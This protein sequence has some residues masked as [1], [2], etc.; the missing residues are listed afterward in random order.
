MLFTQCFVI[1]VGLLLVR[2]ANLSKDFFFL[3][4]REKTASSRTVYLSSNRT[5]SM[6]SANILIKETLSIEENCLEKCFET[7]G[8][9]AFSFINMLDNSSQ[10]FLFHSC[11]TIEP[12]CVSP[13]CQSC[14]TGLLPGLGPTTHLEED[15][16]IP[17]L[18][19]QLTKEKAPRALRLEGGDPYHRRHQSEEIV[20]VTRST[21]CQKIVRRSCQFS[22][23]SVITLT[24]AISFSSCLD[25]CKETPNCSHFTY[26]WQGGGGF[27]TSSPCVLYRMCPSTVWCEGC[28]TA[29]PT[30]CHQREQ[31]PTKA[32]KRNDA[33]FVA[34]GYALDFVG[35]VEMLS[36]TGTCGLHLQ[37]MPVPKSRGVAQYVGGQV[38]VC[39]GRSREESYTRTCVGLDISTG[40][41]FDR[42]DL[43]EGREDAS[44]A[45]VGGKMVVLGGWNGQD[46]LDS[47]EIY[48]SL[49]D[50]WQE[51]SGWRLSQSRYQH[52]SAAQGNMLI[53]AGGYPTL[54][55]VEILKLG[56]GD[57][58]G[59]EPLEDMTTGRI[60]H[61]CTMTVLGGDAVL[62]VSGGQNGGEFLSSVE[63]L[64]LGMED[65]AW[66]NLSPMQ[67]PRRNHALLEINYSLLIVGGDTS[68]YTE[69]VGFSYQLVGEV[70][71]LNLT[72]GGNWT[73]MGQILGTP[74]SV[75]EALVVDGEFC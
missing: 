73:L 49:Q 55:T 6:A 8:C 42:G 26:H 68:Y 63:Y 39:A 12:C 65:A 47:V 14:R 23:D 51:V 20:T 18:S 71:Q 37:D 16:T 13:G 59:W 11:S 62:V 22:L 30:L 50:R 36:D 19:K 45:L 24:S 41:W 53:V 27:H 21:P 9:L 67:Q 58:T 52:C 3:A 33:I 7:S 44:S 69:G 46:L 15:R 40:G 64:S 43:K 54:R 35:H 25:S 17:R 4:R 72:E 70:E 28:V 60:A 38:V 75:M 2:Q 29:G 1:L 31:Y 74:R 66:V 56:G 57:W 34:G 10:C 5:C 32:R 48:D 61:A